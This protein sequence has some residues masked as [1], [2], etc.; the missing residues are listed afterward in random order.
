MK[1]E[2]VNVLSPDLEQRRKLTEL[3]IYHLIPELGAGG[4][5]NGL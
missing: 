2:T 1:G 5:F 4:I 3:A